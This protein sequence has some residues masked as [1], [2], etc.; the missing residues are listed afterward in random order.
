MSSGARLLV[1]FMLHVKRRLRGLMSSSFAAPAAACG[2]AAAAP[3]RI[4]ASAPAIAPVVAA[5]GP[6]VPERTVPPACGVEE[7]SGCLREDIE[8]SADEVAP[9]LEYW[10]GVAIDGLQ[11]GTLFDCAYTLHS[12]QS[13][14]LANN[15]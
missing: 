3:S 1:V 5:V 10:P 13:S 6:I 15:E 7:P 9:P 8:L 14:L 4:C 2:L 12:Y 11:M